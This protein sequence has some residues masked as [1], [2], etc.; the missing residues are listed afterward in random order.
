MKKLIIFIVISTG[1]LVPSQ[2][3]ARA[4]AQN[5]GMPPA[6]C[7][8]VL[9]NN[10]LIKDARLWEVYTDRVE[11]EKDGSSHDLMIEKIQRIEIGKEKQRTI[12]FNNNKLIIY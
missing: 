9:K 12:Y 11:Y 8:I 1:L 2:Y 3:S 4:F 7:L 5:L 10:K 6:P